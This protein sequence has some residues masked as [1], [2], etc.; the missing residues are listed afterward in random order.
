MVYTALNVVDA[1]GVNKI[2]AAYELDTTPDLSELLIFLVPQT[3]VSLATILGS[4][5]GCAWMLEKKISL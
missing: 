5:F 3:L 2:A 4:L 1:A